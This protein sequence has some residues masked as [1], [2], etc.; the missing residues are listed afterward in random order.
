MLRVAVFRCL[1]RRRMSFFD[2]Q[3]SAQ[4]TQVIIVGA[5][6]VKDALGDKLPIAIMS[7]GEESM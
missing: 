4:L 2:K 5:R 7:F 6:D 3:G 1:L